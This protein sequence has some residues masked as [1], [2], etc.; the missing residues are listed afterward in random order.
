MSQIVIDARESGTTSGRYVDKLIEYLHKLNIGSEVLVLTKSHRLDFLKGVAPKF[1]IIESPYKEF[2]FSEQI[3][4][5]R[6]I[7]KIKPDLVH[8]AMVQQPIMYRGK[9]VTTMHDLI[10][11]RFK[12]P[13]RN[14]IVF[15]FKQI[16]YKWV[17]RVVARKSAVIITPSEFSKED[18]AKFA[19]VNSRKIVVTYE[20]A[21]KI[22][23][24]PEPIPELVNSKFIMYAGRPQP[25]KNLYRLITAFSALKKDRP[26][27][28]LVLVGKSDILFERLKTWVTTEKIK[29]VVFT[30]FVS[31]GSLRWLYENCQAYV[32]PSLSEGFGL[33]GL[34]AMAHGAPV[35][36]SNA[37]CLPE[38]YGNAA[39]YFD[40]LN[41]E[42]I[43][44][45][46]N[47]VLKSPSLRDE[48]VKKGFS[49]VKKYSWERMAEQTLEV[50]KSVLGET[51]SQ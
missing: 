47:E 7:K 43:S 12:N 3:R 16:V 17:N 32:F 39:A 25:H 10:T 24:Q 19:K 9:V 44:L 35:I 6:Q 42:D 48:L 11:T 22:I 2:T 18:V 29:D 50:Y 23:D 45:R 37:T 21:D 30:D 13:S 26:D 20:A 51:T 31:E 5:N 28:K 36:S 15:N 40:P 4:L 8:F 49:Q 34:E 41:I 38:I 46:I 1:N 33:P 27:L 14:P